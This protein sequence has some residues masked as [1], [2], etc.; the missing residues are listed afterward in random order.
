MSEGASILDKCKKC[1]HFQVCAN[2]MKNQLFIR[3]KMMGEENPE[4]EEFISS[5]EVE[6]CIKLAGRVQEVLFKKEETMQILAAEGQ[7]YYDKLKMSEDT[8]ESL[9]GKIALYE[10]ERKHFD[11]IRRNTYNSAVES[12]AEDIYKFICNKDNW[13]SLK[14][15][16]LENGEC[17]WLKSKLEGL[18]RG[19]L[20]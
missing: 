12:F 19:R 11:D 9:K 1:F 2:I 4:C 8:V 17:Y 15:S 3:E 7:E 13:N 20:R 16:W 10:T 5:E 6:R 18:V 14:S